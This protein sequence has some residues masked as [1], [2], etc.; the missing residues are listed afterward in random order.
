M[1]DFADDA[2][3]TLFWIIQPVIGRNEAGIHAVMQRQGLMN[4]AK[5]TLEPKRERSEPAVET[6]HEKR[7]ATRVLV[8]P[9]DFAQLIF[10]QAQRLF[11]EDVLTA[12]QR[13][14]HL[15]GMQM[16][17]R[18]DYDGVDRLIADQLVFIGGTVVKSELL[19]DV[20]GMG[21]VGGA[22]AD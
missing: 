16:M 3:T 15:S 19:R 7:L 20:M 13:C 8:S 17:T 12:L 21:T 2:A 1:A 6:N 14:Q 22:H 5:K 18:G 4:S 10:I 9:H 11:T